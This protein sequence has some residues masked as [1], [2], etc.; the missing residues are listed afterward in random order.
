[1]EQQSPISS[2]LIKKVKGVDGIWW[3]VMKKLGSGSFGDVFLGVQSKSNPP[4]NQPLEIAIKVED[5]FS[6]CPQLQHEGRMLHFL[7]SG[8]AGNDGFC[9]PYFTSVVNGAHRVLAM[10]LMGKSLGDCLAMC[11]GQKFSEDHAFVS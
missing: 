2:S 9:K 7:N 5:A 8:T 4:N 1:M 10:E 11:E 3:R 6:R